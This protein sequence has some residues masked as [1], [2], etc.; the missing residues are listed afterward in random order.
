MSP[1]MK[2]LSVH[3]LSL[4]TRRTKRAWAAHSTLQP[5]LLDRAT[6]ALT[7]TL[8]LPA[9][10]PRAQRDRSGAGQRARTVT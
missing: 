3:T 2:Q 1:N 4:V 8:D 7:M 5:I 6:D 10:G 9:G